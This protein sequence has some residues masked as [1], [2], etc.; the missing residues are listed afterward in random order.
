MRTSR[1]P[2]AGLAVKSPV[3]I[4]NKETDKLKEPEVVEAKQSVKKKVRKRSKT[5]NQDN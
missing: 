4:N 3:D 2:R 5:S 1:K